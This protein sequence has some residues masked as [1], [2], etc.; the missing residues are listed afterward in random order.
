MNDLD[1]LLIRVLATI[2]GLLLPIRD[3]SK[4]APQNRYFGFEL[5]KAD[6]VPMRIGGDVNSRKTGERQLQ[7]LADAG[8]V[9]I[10]KHGRA[11]F[12]LCMLSIRGESRARGLCGW[13]AHKEAR[14]F[15]SELAKRSKKYAESIEGRWMPE[16]DM[17]NGKGW[18]ECSQAERRGLVDVEFRFLPAAFRG[19]ADCGSS[20]NGHVCYR[21]TEAGQTQLKRRSRPPAVEPMPTEFDVALAELYAKSLR[22][23]IA[24]MHSAE[25]E[26]TRE[27]GPIPLIE[28]MIGETQAEALAGGAP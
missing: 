27:I 15:L 8:F 26:I 12:P 19:W 20:A 16:I 17:N 22:E 5:Y 18:D 3:W 14:V 7:D 21:L 23:K 1:A 4:N 6:G 2:D 13:E 10:T 28:S 11:K 24:E 25:P 9:T